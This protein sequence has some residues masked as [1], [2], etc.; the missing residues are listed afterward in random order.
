MVR[1]RQVSD[2]GRRVS[3]KLGIEKNARLTVLRVAQTH[4]NRSG[5]LK[6]KGFR[7]TALTILNIELLAAIATANTNTTSNE[8]SGRLRNERTEKRMS[9]SKPSIVIPSLSSGN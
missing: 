2:F 1:L 5:S 8:N 7:I 9:L 4:T 3:M 6:D